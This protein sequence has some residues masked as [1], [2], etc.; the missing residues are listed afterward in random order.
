M[1]RPLVFE[2]HWLSVFPVRAFPGANLMEGS[3]GGWG[4]QSA[5]RGPSPAHSS[6]SPP[7]PLLPRHPT[8][9]LCVP[10]RCSSPSHFAT[11]ARIILLHLG[12]RGQLLLAIPDLT[13]DPISRAIS[14]GLEDAS[15][16]PSGDSELPHSSKA[17]ATPSDVSQAPAWDTGL[18]MENHCTHSRGTYSS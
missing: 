9:V 10:L 1:R 16:P 14:A 7:T 18:P 6:S 12:L 3:R 5:R 13:W 4:A 8:P 17:A 11:C 15:L 2:E